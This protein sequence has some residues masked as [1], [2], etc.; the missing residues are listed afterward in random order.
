MKKILLVGSNS[1]I[2]K[3]LILEARYNFIEL[4]RSKSS[5]FNIL[6]KSTYPE[7]DLLDGIVYFPG[8]IN[9]KPFSNFKEKDFINDYEINVLGLINT[10]QFYY[11]SLNRDSSIV[12]LS[13]IAANF[14]MPYHTSISMCKSS[15]EALTGLMDFNVTIPDAK[16]YGSIV[17]VS[18]VL[19]EG[20][21]NPT[22]LKQDPITGSYSAFPYNSNTG[23]GARWDSSASTMTRNLTVYWP[24]TAL[25]TLFIYELSPVR[26]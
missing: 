2:A 8:T 13:S 11:K 1:S 9:L 20:T 21:T 14:G 10:L 19:P 6:D 17:S 12:T 5:L 26:Q 16:D 25:N 18:F 22:Y 24:A 15:V 4:S 7:I 3:S 23:E